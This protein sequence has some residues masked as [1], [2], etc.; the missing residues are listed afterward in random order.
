MFGGEKFVTIIFF[1]LVFKSSS[2][3][4]LDIFGHLK[5]SNFQKNEF[6]RARF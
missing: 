3:I 2:Q 6:L 5:M 1:F 4:K